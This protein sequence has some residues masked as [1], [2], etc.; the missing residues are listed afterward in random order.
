VGLLA[1]A[2]AALAATDPIAHAAI[3]GE[4][5]RPKGHWGTSPSW[6]PGTL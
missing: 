6:C 4:E 5:K 1:G 2:V 3:G